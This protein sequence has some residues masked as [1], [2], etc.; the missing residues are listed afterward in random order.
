MNQLL[1]DLWRE[2]SG[3]E[4]AEWVV[5]VFLLMVVGLAV[6]NVTLMQTLSSVVSDA[7][8]LVEA[9]IS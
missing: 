5:V 9:L 8:G 1:T 7:V 3:A 2:K 6:Y 4:I